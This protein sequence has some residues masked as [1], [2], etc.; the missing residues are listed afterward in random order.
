ME[1]PLQYFFAPKSVAMMGVSPNWS[2]INS[3]LKQFIQLQTPE[4]VYP[5][6]PNYPEVEGLKAYP[7]LSDIPEP[8]DLVLIS[9]PARLVS[10]ALKQCEEKK[11]KAI[12]ILTSGF[13]EMGGEEGERRHRLMTDFVKRT[14]IR[15]VGPNCYGNVSVPDKFAGMPNTLLAVTRPIGRISLAFQSGGLA[16]NI[17]SA[18]L[19]RYIGLAYVVSSGNEADVEVADCLRFYADDEQTQVI[20]CYVEQFRNAQKF[21]EAADLCAERRKPIVVLKIGR[22][23]AGQ[24]M[25]QAHT[26]SLAGS[27]KI[28]DAVLKQYGVTRVFS[29]DEMM[30]TMAILHSRQLPKGRGVAAL[31]L[32]GGANAVISDLAAELG[33]AFPPFGEASEQIIRSKLYDF[34]S[35]TNPLD[36]TGPGI[37]EAHVHQAALD[38]LGSDPNM[39]IILHQTG[40]TGRMDAQGPA[41]KILLAAMKK[42]PDK[43]WLKVGS[44]AGTF[45]EKP[46]GMPDLIEPITELDGVPFLQGTENVLRAAKALI[47]YAEFQRQRDKENPAQASQIRTPDPAKRG[48]QSPAWGTRKSP[49][50]AQRARLLALCARLR[51]ARQRRAQG[52]RVG[53]ERAPL[54][55]TARATRESARRGHN[56]NKE[57][58]ASAQKLLR[59]ANGQSLTEMA[60]KQILALYGIPVTKECLATSADDAAR[61][62]KE[63]GFPVAMKIVSPQILH[64]TEAG[65]VALNIATEQDA[66][67]SFERIIHNA[68]RYKPEAELQGVSVQE[69]VSGGHEVIVG[70]TRDPQFGPGVLLGL[71]GIFVETLKDVVLR[72]PPLSDADARA[73]VNSLKGKAILAGARGA[74]P[75]DID[76]LV[77]VLLKFSQLCLDLRDDLAEID[78]NPLVVFERGKG[79]KA[80]DCLMVPV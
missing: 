22:S 4:K 19:D 64:K 50:H 73:M 35:V 26:G 79:A 1:G 72:V 39:H 70:M 36:I 21:L 16:I 54:A 6:N 10:D 37:Q 18:C 13:A 67:A 58:Q 38:A 57:R 40:G 42:Y 47:N 8:V 20:G 31:T 45:H 76:A 49:T 74:K 62:A 14:G 2:Y 53:E 80:L 28:V 51:R 60:G 41:G 7:R 75:A 32:S 65:G 25:A 44:A 12:N 11:V 33:V 63:I 43:I 52:E 23:E 17:V 30:E 46:R 24:R 66:C 15:I 77:D 59:A 68:R 78:I 55:P 5:V 56:P 48:A 9:V 71:G 29:I 61:A 3:V 34:V 69:M 27:D